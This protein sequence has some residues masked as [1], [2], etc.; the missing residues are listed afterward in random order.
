MNLCKLRPLRSSEE[1]TRLSEAAA[2]DNHTVLA[3]T[4]LVIKE[5]AIVGYASLGGIPIMNVWV[6][7]KQVRAV[8]TLSM[9][10]AA[11]AVLAERWQAVVVPCMPTSPLKPYMAKLGYAEIGESVL[12]LKK[13]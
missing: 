4:H 8:D 11:E 9:M 2:A 3:A 7:S 6:D 5:G 12:H 10:A 1:L 13:L